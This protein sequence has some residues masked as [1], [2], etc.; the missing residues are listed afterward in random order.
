MNKQIVS[1]NYQII[2]QSGTILVVGVEECFS[3]DW[4]F[5]FCEVATLVQQMKQI[6]IE[7]SKT[8]APQ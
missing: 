5:M 7:G 1:S 2:L 4:S 6:V 3:E 8:A